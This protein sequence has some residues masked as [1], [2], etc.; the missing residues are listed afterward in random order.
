MTSAPPSP[1]TDALRNAIVN[2]GRP[3]KVIAQQTGIDRA[4]LARFIK[5]QRT[6]RL[7]SADRIAA[8]LGLE[9]R[10]MS[11]A[12]PRPAHAVEPA[13]F[14]NPL[15]AFVAAWNA[16]WP[17]FPQ[18]EQ[19]ARTSS[20]ILLQFPN[21]HFRVVYRR[22][23][24]VRRL[25]AGAVHCSRAEME[26]VAKR[27]PL[28][29][30]LVATWPDRAFPEPFGFG[31]QRI[32]LID[33][34]AISEADGGRGA[35]EQVVDALTHAFRQLADDFLRPPVNPYGEWD[36][37]RFPIGSCPLCWCGVNYTV[38][39]GWTTGKRGRASPGQRFEEVRKSSGASAIALME[40]QKYAERT[41]KL[42]GAF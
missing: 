16:R 40:W 11:G 23:P 18:F 6:L 22:G 37:A 9:L 17:G 27:W 34:A 20:L 25:E 2:C 30:A 32:W 24:D 21:I 13:A 36:L 15:N 33:S 31:N 1:L 4:A 3:P 5:G 38:Y 8:W 42:R 26:S 14:A 12:R 10:T 29:K 7:D 41:E 28:Y 19:H 35:A 39:E